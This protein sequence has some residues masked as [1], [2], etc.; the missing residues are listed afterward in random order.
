[1][2]RN[3]IRHKRLFAEAI[4]FGII[5]HHFHTITMEMNKMD[6]IQSSLEASYLNF[7][8]QI[9]RHSEKIIINS[10]ETLRQTRFLFKQSTN[11]F[12]SLRKKA[13]KIDVGFREQAI[14]KFN[15]VSKK[16]EELFKAFEHDL[17]A[18]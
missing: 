14:K 8:K 17:L 9:E 15:E 7:R 1:V 13:L 18:R 10:K 11:S 5:G 2:A 3:L 6:N 16:A 12:E 4:R